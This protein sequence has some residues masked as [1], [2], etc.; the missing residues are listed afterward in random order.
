MTG[1][2]KTKLSSRKCKKE[3][4]IGKKLAL[5]QASM[6][7][8]VEEILDPVLGDIVL[9]QPPTFESFCIQYVNS[10][11]ETFEVFYVIG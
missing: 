7:N 1:T 8:G 11:Q 6:E 9:I 4:R 3:N 10:V 5:Y 2:K